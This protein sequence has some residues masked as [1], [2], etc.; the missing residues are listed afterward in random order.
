MKIA[1][2]DG[3]LE[4]V[5]AIATGVGS[6]AL[7]IVGTLTEHAAFRSLIGGEVVLG[8]WEAVM[9]T[10]AIAVGVY[11]LGYGEFWPRVK[12]LCLTP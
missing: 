9:G 11:L 10:L 12:H 8:T 3:I 6:V 4:V 5:V 2:T 1:L 7:T